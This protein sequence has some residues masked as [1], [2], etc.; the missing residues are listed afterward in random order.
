MQTVA[1]G[2]FGGSRPVQCKFAYFRPVLCSFPASSRG[3]A[4]AGAATTG[5]VDTYSSDEDDG[6]PGGGE[7]T[8]EHANRKI[9]DIDTVSAIHENAPTSLLRDRRTKEEKEQAKMERKAKTEERRGARAQRALQRGSAAMDVDDEPGVKAEPISPDKIARNLPAVREHDSLL[10]EDKDQDRDAQGRRVRNFARTGGM[11]LD[12]EE[13]IDDDEGGLGKKT[14]RVDE[15]E[16]E[17]E[18]EEEDMAGDFVQIEGGVSSI[19]SAS[20]PGRADGQADP[21]SKI[22]TFQFPNLFP[23]FHPRKIDAT[24]ENVNGDAKPDIKP[25]LKPTAA[26]L[27]GKKKVLDVPP[28]E[29]RIGTLC[30][31]KS[32]KVKMVLGDDIVMNVSLNPLQKSQYPFQRNVSAKLTLTKTHLDAG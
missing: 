24:G 2:V 1:A 22:F 13:E 3:G 27:K 25:D 10:D 11:D 26:Q 28:V 7:T 19:A 16:S 17:E 20:T 30:V 6:G 32:G 23:K 9:I 8:E 12:D 15:S 4:P 5:H 31:M 29:G 14:Q 21:E 18:E